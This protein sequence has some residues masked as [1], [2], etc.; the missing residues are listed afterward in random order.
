MNDLPLPAIMADP[1][2]EC[3]ELDRH[4]R[5]IQAVSERLP[6]NNEVRA[7]LLVQFLREHNGRGTA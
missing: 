4:M 3:R 5:L 7:A 1:G 2:T 6:I